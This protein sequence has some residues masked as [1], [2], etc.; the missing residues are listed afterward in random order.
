MTAFAFATSTLGR[1][2]SG[3]LAF[4]ATRERRG[5]R[6][7]RR[8]LHPAA[9]RAPARLLVA[10]G[11]PVELAD[12]DHQQDARRQDGGDESGRSVHYETGDAERH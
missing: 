8:M 12:A 5:S 11:P 4:H 1:L 6:L 10:A 3:A 9:G 2:S 7:I